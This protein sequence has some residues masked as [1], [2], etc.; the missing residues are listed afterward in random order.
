MRS[1][2]FVRMQAQPRHDPFSGMVRDRACGDHRLGRAKF[3]DEGFSHRRI[4]SGQP[5]LETVK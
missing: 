5:R 1:Q 4:M 3:V 2:G